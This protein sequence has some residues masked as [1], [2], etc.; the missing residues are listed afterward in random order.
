MIYNADVCVT[1]GDVGLTAIHTMM[2]GVPVITH[3]YFPS[4]GPEFETIHDGV[5]GCFYQKGSVESLA[6]AICN[7][8]SSHQDDRK[9]VRLACYNEIDTLWTPNFQIEVIKK[10]CS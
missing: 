9:Q 10:A 2:Y 3:D 4:Q 7:W 1:P 5:T 6:T 8:L